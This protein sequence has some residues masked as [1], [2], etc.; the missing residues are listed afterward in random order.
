MAVN[1]LT[2]FQGNVMRK[3]GEIFCHNLKVNLV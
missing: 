3:W 2:N 1:T